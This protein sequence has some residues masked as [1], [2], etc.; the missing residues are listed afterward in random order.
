VNKLEVG[1]IFKAIP[2]SILPRKWEGKQTVSM[3]CQFE[4]IAKLENGVWQ[5]WSGVYAPVCCFGEFWVVKKDGSVSQNAVDQLA[6]SLGWDGNLEADRD[7]APNVVV[8]LT[9]EEDTYTNSAG[10]SRTS[11]KASWMRP[12]DYDP[13]PKGATPEEAK[14]MGSQFGSLLRAAAGAKAKAAKPVKGPERPKMQ[15]ADGHDLDATPFD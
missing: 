4:I 9:V 6:E 10:V 14:Q 5:Q 1:G 2:I 12:G 8:Q 3:S 11:F 7:G 13:K 15:T